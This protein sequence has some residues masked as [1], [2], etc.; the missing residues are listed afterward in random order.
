MSANDPEASEQ[1]RIERNVQ[2]TV[3][4]SALK[5]IRGIVDE[6]RRQ[7]AGNARFLRAFMKYGW[8]IMLLVSLALAH[9]LG[10]F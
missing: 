10:L 3:G 7:E 2:R 8:I 5:E 9:V 1:E 6:E 4:Q